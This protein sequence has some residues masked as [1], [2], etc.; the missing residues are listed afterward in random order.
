MT[1][2]L[3][4]SLL[5]CRKRSLYFLRHLHVTYA[6]QQRLPGEF[7]SLLRVYVRFYPSAFHESF[8]LCMLCLHRA[9]K[10]FIFTQLLTR[11]Q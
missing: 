4:R 5:F 1:G 9:G 2:E 7:S 8:I 6:Q 11:N 3:M 10:Q